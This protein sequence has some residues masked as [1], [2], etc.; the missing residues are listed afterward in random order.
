MKKEEKDQLESVTKKYF[1]RN[2]EKVKSKF[3]KRKPILDYSENGTIIE[4]LARIR[5]IDHLDSFLDPDESVLHDPYLLKNIQEVANIIIKALNSNKRICI[6]ADH[7]SDGIFSTATM[8]RYLSRFSDNIYIIFGERSTGHGIENHMEKVEDGTELL[9]ILDSSTNSEDACKELSERGI[10]IVILDH[11]DFENPNEYALIVNPQLDDYPNKKLS[12]AGVVYKTLQ[13]MD[14]TLGTGV[15]DYYLDL[16]AMGMYADMMD[17]SIPE[18]RYIIIQGMKN[19]NNTG[20]K[21][22][23]QVHDKKLSDVDS[24]MIGFTISPLTN[25]VARL[26]KLQLALELLI[27]DNQLVALELAYEIKELNDQRKVTQRNLVESYKEQINFDSKLLIAIDEKASKGFNGLVANNLAEEYQRPALV[28]RYVEADEL[29][30]RPA[31]VTGSFRSYGDFPMKKFLSEF[32]FKHKLI[33]YAVGHEFA[34]GIS[35]DYKN[36]ERFI[37][38]ANDKLSK[39]QFQQ[40]REYDLELSVEDI[41]QALLHDIARFDYLTGTGMPQ[42]RF[43]VRG[44][45]IEEKK[46]MGGNND[47]VKLSCDGLVVMK[48]RANPDV[49][50]ADLG[51]DD[52][53]DVVGT[54]NLNSWFNKYKKTWT[55]TPQMFADDYEKR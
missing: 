46:I 9:I 47:T 5:G 16:V 48:F 12:G 44:L 11:H 43:L 32:K 17:V 13:V 2:E 19:I 31:K 39:V 33:D 40:E 30:G 22:I 54:L 23:L 35:M 10:E 3:K 37:E 27:A 34:G 42:S 52:T 6:S 51:Y 14:D 25:G 36:L 24:N 20:L 8:Y 1:P 7:D 53:I 50:G 4:K 38:L 29:E 55:H 28:M 26:D 18:N 15:V 45:Y 41:D 49:W 21:A